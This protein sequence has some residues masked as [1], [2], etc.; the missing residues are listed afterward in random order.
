MKTYSAKPSDIEKKWILI[1]AQD[2]VLGRL[3]VI[4]ADILRG[5]HKT[6]F[7][8]HMDCGDNVVIVNAAKVHLTGK[9]RQQKSYW[10]HTGFAGG[11]KYTYAGPT[12]EGK[13]PERVIVAAVKRMIPAGPLGRK[14]M[15]NLKIYGGAEHPHE[16]QQPAKM[17]IAKMS[18]K[19]VK[20]V[21]Q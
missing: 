20:R 13:H 4:V 2:A 15:G 19:N 1:D 6:T 14:I 21:A 7:T 18:S 10:R 3:A 9:K 12:L 17:D 8:P 16:A 5:K 11:L